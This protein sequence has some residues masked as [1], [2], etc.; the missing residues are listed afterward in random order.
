AA[1]LGDATLH[2]VFD[3]QGRDNVLVHINGS[4]A[5]DLLLASQ[6][7]QERHADRPEGELTTSQE[8]SGR[9]ESH[10]DP[11]QA[12]AEGSKTDGT[13]VPA[14]GEAN[15]TDHNGDV[16]TPVQKTGTEG[17]EGPTAATEDEGRARTVASDKSATDVAFPAQ[18][19]KQ[20]G[21]EAT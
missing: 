12:A 7:A 4:D 18:V 14:T 21:T 17:S 11:D 1:P 6:T 10:T 2:A 13:A 16:E 5:V 9:T 3:E 19:E 15:Q 20:S 8:A